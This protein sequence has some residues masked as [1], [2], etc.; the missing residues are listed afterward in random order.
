VVEGALH[1][2]AVARHCLLFQAQEVGARWRH[3]IKRLQARDL[4]A[5]GT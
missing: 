2:D 3:R 1:L 5:G 4:A